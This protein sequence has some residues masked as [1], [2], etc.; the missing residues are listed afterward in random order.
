MRAALSASLVNL[1]AVADIVEIN[2]SKLHIEFVKHPVIAHAQFEFRS[3]L[4][5]LVLEIFQSRTHFINLVLH[6][7]TDGGGQIVEGF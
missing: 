5:S 6:G 3:A 7:F 1:A 4:Q 2:P